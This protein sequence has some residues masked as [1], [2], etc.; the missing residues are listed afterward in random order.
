VNK[1]KVRRDRVRY[2]RDRRFILREG[3]PLGGMTRWNDLLPVAVEINC[4]LC[5]GMGGV[6]V[7]RYDVS[8]SPGDEWEDC[9]HCDGGMWTRDQMD[10]GIYGLVEGT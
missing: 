9:T 3:K 6:R 1:R 2:N 10:I 7:V 4:F 5:G 8:G